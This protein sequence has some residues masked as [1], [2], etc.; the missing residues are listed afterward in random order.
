MA[1]QTL[2][3]PLS[4]HMSFIGQRADKVHV[5][6]V[7]GVTEYEDANGVVRQGV[8]KEVDRYTISCDECGG[9]GYYD[10]RGDVICEGCG[11]VLSGAKA[12]LPMEFEKDSD[13][14]ETGSFGA[15]RGLGT[16][17]D[18]APGTHEPSVPPKE[19]T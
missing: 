5:T 3:V 4:R 1:N 13:S 17:Q 11:R 9:D 15:S 18:P 8:V 19:D 10:Q 6:D 12:V 16:E 14:Q 7:A 2:V